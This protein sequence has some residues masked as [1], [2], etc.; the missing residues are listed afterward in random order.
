MD[1]N[2]TVHDGNTDESGSDGDNENIFENTYVIIGIV[3]VSLIFLFMC[4]AWLYKCCVKNKEDLE[5]IEKQQKEPQ[6]E[7]TNEKNIHKRQGSTEALEH[8]RK[9]TSMK[10]LQ[11]KDLENGDSNKQSPPKIGRPTTE[12][13]SEE[14]AELELEEKT[15]E[16]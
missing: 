13:E 1:T 8:Y 10:K 16:D 11:L 3:V 6:R 7:E 5:K 14:N 12:E 9:V 4:L 15:K 2:T